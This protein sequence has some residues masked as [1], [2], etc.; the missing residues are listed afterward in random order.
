[1]PEPSVRVQVSRDL[2]HLIPFFLE[3]RR[4]R[5][6]QGLAWLEQGE[7]TQVH[8]LGH[9]FKGACG[10]Y[11]FHYLAGLG[12]ELEQQAELEPAR[13]LLLQMREHLDRV[14]VEFV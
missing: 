12:T 4:E 1:M 9:D 2:A 11:G 13:D 5:I 14:E 10:G 6:R 3:N 8:L 7:L